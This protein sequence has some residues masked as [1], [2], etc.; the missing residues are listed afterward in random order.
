LGV[1]VD[2]ITG[3][4]TSGH[5]QIGGEI[6]SY[7]G[8]TPASNRFDD[9]TRAV[10]DT[11]ATTHLANAAVLGLTNSRFDLQLQP[12]VIVNADVSATAA[13][14]QTKLNL[15]NVTAY[16]DTATDSVL[17]KASFSTDNFTV[18][19]G[20][21]IIKDKGIA[22]AEIQDVAAGTILGNLTG[23][24]A[25]V[26]EVSTSGIVQNGVN[27]LFTT[28]DTGSSVMTRRANSLKTTS[29]FSSISGT[30]VS[31]SGTVINLPV[32][33]VSTPALSGIKGQGAIVTVSYDTVGGYTA[34]TV[35]YGGNGYTEGEQL[36]VPGSYFPGGVDGEHDVSFTVETTGSNI[37][38]TVYLGLERVTKIAEANS[39]VMTDASKNLGTAGNKF[40][41]VHATT[42]Y[43]NLTG[44]SVTADVTGDLT[45]TADSATNL[46]GGTIGSIPYQSA[47]GVTTRLE[48]G[49][50]GRYL[51]TQGPGQPP[52]WNEIIIPDGA[53]DTLTGTT[54][55][56]GVVNSSLTSVGTLTS[57]TVS[58]NLTIATNKLTVNSTSGAVGINNNLTVGGNL[59]VTGLSRVS[60]NNAVIASGI[61]QTGATLLEANINVITSVGVNT[62]V[63]LPDSVAGLRIIIKN[64]A[65]NNLFIYPSASARINDKLLNE[66]VILEPDAALEYFCSTSAVGGSGGQWYTI[67]AT[68]A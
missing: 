60:V 57:L 45:G 33:S 28:L 58:G 35:T 59:A 32:T 37:D 22:Y 66:A 19:A 50:S 4:P 49:T 1:V 56:T 14:E 62:G 13:I 42:F 65:T 54:L 44:A 63:R 2:D 47:I 7:T 41:N 40:N 16:V 64:A 34:I 48:P 43:G 27:S 9:V 3:W 8:T 46:T 31:G 61:D 25:S 21:V 51:K 6:F 68:F 18:T 67:N 26:Q 24:A 20:A 36:I 5:F 55:A 29:T 11:T 12:G 30:P 39:L 17:G 23:A 52:V 38:T 53:A 10:A 15:T